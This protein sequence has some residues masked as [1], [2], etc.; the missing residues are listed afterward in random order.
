MILK[1]SD[2]VSCTTVAPQS[3]SQM[4]VSRTAFL[5]NQKHIRL[6]YQC[7]PIPEQMPLISQFCISE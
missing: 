3:D 1:Y 6:L 7:S 2:K 4:N 5:V